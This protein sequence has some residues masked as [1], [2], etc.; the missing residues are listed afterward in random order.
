MT[1]LDEPRMPDDPSVEW[2]IVTY[3]VDGYQVRLSWQQTTPRFQIL[4]TD[5]VFSNTFDLRNAID[6]LIGAPA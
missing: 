2:D 1:C 5:A 6:Q 3:E 4:G